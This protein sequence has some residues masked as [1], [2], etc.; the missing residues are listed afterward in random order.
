[1]DDST[2]AL[3]SSSLV[4]S[5]S[6]SSTKC[7][8]IDSRFSSKTSGYV[9][10]GFFFRRVLEDDGGVVEF[11]QVAQQEEAGVIGH[12]RRL[13]HVVSDDH[14]GAA[15]LQLENQVFDLGGGDGIQ[16]RA[17]LVE[18]QHFR[19]DSQGARNAQ[20]LLLAAG[21]PV[22]GLVQ[23]VLYLIPQGGAAQAV[24]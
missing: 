10:F 8:T 22:S 18:Q 3:I 13:L 5:C 15:A 16:R 1:M 12:P 24:L 20:A 2:I 21:K 4:F 17:R 11:D 6:N 23:L 19:I 14:D 9:I 7:R